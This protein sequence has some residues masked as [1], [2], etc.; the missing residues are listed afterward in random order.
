MSPLGEIAG[1]F[2]SPTLRAS[3][4]SNGTTHTA[5]SAPTASLAGLGISPARLAEPPR[6][7]TTAWPSGVTS[8]LPISCPSSAA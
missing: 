4:P 2:P 3:P 1:A 6:T 7:N 8:R 5:C